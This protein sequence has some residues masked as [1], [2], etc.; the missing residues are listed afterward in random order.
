MPVLLIPHLLT[1]MLKVLG[2]AGVVFVLIVVLK[3][4]EARQTANKGQNGEKKDF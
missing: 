2:F 1:Y 3:Y 4:L